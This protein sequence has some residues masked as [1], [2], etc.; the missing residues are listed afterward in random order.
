LRI[1][2]ADF[3]PKGRL[4]S[5]TFAPGAIRSLAVVAHG[6]DHAVDVSV[7]RIGFY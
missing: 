5:K 1:P 7:R 4:L 2:F 6:R 3:V